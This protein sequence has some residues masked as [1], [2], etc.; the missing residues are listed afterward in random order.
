VD[1]IVE[2]RGELANWFGIIRMGACVR[3]AGNQ[4][5]SASAMA[6]MRRR[7]DAL[8]HGNKTADKEK[9]GERLDQSLLTLGNLG[10]WKGSR[11]LRTPWRKTKLQRSLLRA[12][13]DDHDV[14]H[15]CKRSSSMCCT[16]EDEGLPSTATGASRRLDDSEDQSG[17][18]LP[19]RASMASALVSG[20]NWKVR[21]WR[22]KAD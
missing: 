1:G 18:E 19:Q 7:R 11:T 15:C 17:V 4:R 22:R 21:W 20:S 12:C 13:D 8:E 6:T 16:D 9:G 2:S 3:A 10:N 5:H 14:P